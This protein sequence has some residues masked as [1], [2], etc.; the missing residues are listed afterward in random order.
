MPEPEAAWLT[1]LFVELM[2]GHNSAVTGDVARVLGRAP[3]DLAEYARD[4]AAA[5]VWKD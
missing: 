4:A 1:G 3:R 5:G 2:D